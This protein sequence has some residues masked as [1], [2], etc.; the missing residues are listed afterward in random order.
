MPLMETLMDVLASQV[1]HPSQPEIAACAHLRPMT[2]EWQLFGSYAKAL[3][4]NSSHGHIPLCLHNPA[5]TNTK[6]DRQRRT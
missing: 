5:N 1:G 2:A 3:A 6:N 4:T